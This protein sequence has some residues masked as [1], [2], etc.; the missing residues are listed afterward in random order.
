MN[1]ISFTE[2]GLYIPKADV[3]I[4][5]IKPVEKALIT[6]AHADHARVGMGSYIGHHLSIAVIKAR[7]GPY[8]ASC[9]VQYG[10]KIQIGGVVFS[11]H[12]A[13][14]IPGSAQIRI[15][16]KGYVT[17]VSGDYKLED[18]GVST[19]FE[20]LRCNCFVTESTFGLPSFSWEQ[21]SAVATKLNSWW[22]KNQNEG[23][24]SVLLTYSAGKSQR[25]LSLLDG[26]IGP[27][28]AHGAVA[29][30]NKVF[31]DN[32]VKL[33]QTDQLPSRYS[34]KNKSDYMVIAT[35]FG[36]KKAWSKYFFPYSI[37]SVSGWSAQSKLDNLK[38]EDSGFALSD[39]AD[40]QGLITAVQVTQASKII[41][42]HGYTKQFTKTLRVLGFDAEEAPPH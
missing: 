2:R 20:H 1:L 27:I 21:Q 7:F 3:Y 26:S 35:P 8:I 36:N 28:Y 40:F 31:R 10:E 15:E 18:D 14:H 12:P 19:P 5:P 23:K 34:N 39:H 25:V 30:M 6:H 41:V 37:A 4:D 9:G 33:P 16:C 11:F 42:T 29:Q 38:K 13:G 22:K 24:A 32:G 17:V